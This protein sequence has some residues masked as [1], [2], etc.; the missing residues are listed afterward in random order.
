MNVLGEQGT[1]FAL[2]DV[3]GLLLMAEL[4]SSRAT[5]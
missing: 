5:A 1:A 2:L 4:H 3:E